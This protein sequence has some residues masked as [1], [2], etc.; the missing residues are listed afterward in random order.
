YLVSDPIMKDLATISEED[1]AKARFA[2]GTPEPGGYM[3]YIIN[4]PKEIDFSS[5]IK[6]G[7][8]STCFFMLSP[9][10]PWVGYK[11]IGFLGNRLKKYP[12]KHTPRKAALYLA[13]IVRM[14]EEIGTGGGGFRFL[15]SAFLQ[16]AAEKTGNDNY[17]KFSEECTNIGDD[18]RNYAFN[19]ASQVK[20]REANMNSFNEL[21]DMLIEI[22]KREKDFFT[23]LKKGV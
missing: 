15:Y 23:R 18:W 19:A 17:Q 21:G 10:L 13:N 3:Y 5:C 7:I 4:T 14:Q 12:I 11:A 20:A 8:K 1:L 6:K 16:E 22:G 2:K 9:P